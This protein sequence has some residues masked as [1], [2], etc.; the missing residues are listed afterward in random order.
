M[1]PSLRCQT[2][3]LVH[4]QAVIFLNAP[5][6]QPPQ[7]VLLGQVGDL[8]YSLVGVNEMVSAAQASMCS[9]LYGIP[10]IVNQREKLV[11]PAP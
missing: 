4:R 6:P 2:A 5:G 1:A 10:L 3:D 7:L 8:L 9:I 11:T